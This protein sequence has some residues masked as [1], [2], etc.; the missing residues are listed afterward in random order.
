M[1]RGTGSNHDARGAGQR[2]IKTFRLP[3]IGVCFLA[4]VASAC[5]SHSSTPSTDAGL[6]MVS[7]VPLPGDTTRFDYES[8]DPQ[9]G[10]LYIAHL[11]AGAIIVFDTGSNTVVGTIDNVAG[12]HGVFVVPQL[13]RLYA[14]ATGTNEVAVIDTTT[15]SVVASVPVGVYPDGLTYDPEVGKVYVSNESGGTDSVID[16][17]TNQLVATIQLDGEAGNTQYDPTSHRIYVA[18]QTK[19]DVVSIDPATD[20][21][22]ERYD[23]PGCDEPHGLLID[24]QDEIAYVACQSNAKLL[25]FDLQAKRVTQTFDTG[26]RPDV[27][28]ADPALHLLYVAAEDGI[29]ATFVQENGGLR[30]G[31]KGFVGPNAHVVAVDQETHAIYLPLKDVEGHPVLRQM[32]ISS[33]G[34]H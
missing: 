24:S 34:T 2:K 30:T 14:S 21:I 18:V 7:D 22:V 31:R 23:M 13:G 33:P 28:A 29:L 6:T 32:T 16:A 15:L 3:V 12:V 17:M 8:F 19:N 27:L 25:V 11:G 9:A 1:V 10:R 5:G 20:E 26:D 4:F